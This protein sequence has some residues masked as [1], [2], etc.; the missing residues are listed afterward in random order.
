MAWLLEDCSTNSAYIDRT[1]MMGLP[2]T[3]QA[4]FEANYRARLRESTTVYVGNLSFDTP[5]SRLWE[6]FSATGRIKD[7]VMGLDRI[8]KT[9]CGFCFV[10]YYDRSDAED[11]VRYMRGTRIDDRVVKVDWDKG[12]VREE[13][14]FLARGAHGGQVRD[15]YREDF[16]EGR[17]GLGWNAKVQMGLQQQLLQR[18]GQRYGDWALGGAARAPQR[19]RI[20]WKGGGGKGRRERDPY[21]DYGGAEAPAAKRPRQ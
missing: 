14:R 11:C 20:G 15:V 13:Q 18:A 17:G 3:E 7:L 19:S 12:N 16:D 1:Q 6:I 10:E 8:Q 9:P 5:E 21:A 4:E 2:E